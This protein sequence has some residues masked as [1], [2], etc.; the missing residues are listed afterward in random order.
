MTCDLLPV[1]CKKIPVL[2]KN[3]KL[4]PS[5]KETQEKLIASGN[6]TRK[7]NLRFTNIPERQGE[8]RCDIVNDIIE[9]DRTKDHHARYSF[10][11]CS[12]RR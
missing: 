6:Y 9:N 8:N 11:R 4:R 3:V 10:S 2:T 5:L 7:E 1:T 12:S